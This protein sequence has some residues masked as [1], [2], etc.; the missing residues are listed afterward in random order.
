MK[1]VVFHLK[2]LLLMREKKKKRDKPFSSTYSLIGATAL[3]IATLAQI[4][5]HANVTKP[6]HLLIVMTKIVFK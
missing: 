6:S 1:L 3:M 4:S 2:K 5:L